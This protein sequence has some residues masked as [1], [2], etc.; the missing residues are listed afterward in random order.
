M[1]WDLASHTGAEPSWSQAGSQGPEHQNQTITKRGQVKNLLEEPSQRSGNLKKKI[2]L[3]PVS[4]LLL[5]T[6]THIEA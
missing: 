1:N 6:S 3:E 2:C 5:K 4:C